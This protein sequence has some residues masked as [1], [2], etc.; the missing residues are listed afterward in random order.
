MG[1]L[2]TTGWQR[3]KDSTPV[4]QATLDAQSPAADAVPPNLQTV[5]LTQTVE[6]QSPATP[7]VGAA[8]ATTSE[9]ALDPVTGKEA[10]GL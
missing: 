3:N 7:T 8:T 1:K 6:S 4:P 9:A 10:G 2:F 5:A